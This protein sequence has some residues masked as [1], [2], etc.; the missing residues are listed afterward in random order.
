MVASQKANGD[1]N[2]RGSV[3]R[4]SRPRRTGREEG[5]KEEK[6]EEEEKGGYKV[7][8]IVREG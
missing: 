6:E 5:G 3:R 8:K 2:K 4:A 7:N 1:P